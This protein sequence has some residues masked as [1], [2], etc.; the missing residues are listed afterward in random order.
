MQGAGPSPWPS[1]ISRA[2]QLTLLSWLHIRITWEVSPPLPSPGAA[3]LI[4]WGLHHSIFI[5]LD[6]QSESAAKVFRVLIPPDR[7][8]WALSVGRRGLAFTLSLSPSGGW[9]GGCPEPR[10]W[11]G[12]DVQAP[13]VGLP[14][15]LTLSMGTAAGR[16]VSAHSSSLALF[17]SLGTDG[18][19]WQ[20]ASSHAGP[21]DLGWEGFAGGAGSA[22][23]SSHPWAS[24][25]ASQAA[26]LPDGRGGETVVSPCR[27]HTCTQA[28]IHTHTHMPGCCS[29]Q[30]TGTEAG[31]AGVSLPCFWCCHIR[32]PTISSPARCCP[33]NEGFSPSRGWT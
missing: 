12:R 2:T 8:F 27:T 5:K 28:R 25:D 4:Q 14:G 30:N 18:R 26:C 22:W 23:F 9:E 1:D 16:L 11:T 31:A 19:K 21:E 6:S 20:W 7:K 3:L 10:A 33:G 17:P 24:I 32:Q 15:P 29:P 13:G